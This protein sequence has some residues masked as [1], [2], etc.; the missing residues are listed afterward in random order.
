[1]ARNHIHFAP[2]MPTEEGV[3]SGMRGTCDIYIQ[4]DMEAAVKDGIKFYI[5]S[6]NVI[7]T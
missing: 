6:N 4:I 5:S 3:I 2:G 1:M 7:L